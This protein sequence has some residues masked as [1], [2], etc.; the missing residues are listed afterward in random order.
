M[1]GRDQTGGHSRQDPEPVEPVKGLRRHD[2]RIATVERIVFGRDGEPV[3]MTVVGR[4][5]HAALEHRA[6]R[7]D[8]DEAIDERRQADGHVA[9]ACSELERGARPR[10]E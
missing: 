4:A 6:R 7:L 10:S 5:R 2:G 8:R 9:G 3:D 1:A